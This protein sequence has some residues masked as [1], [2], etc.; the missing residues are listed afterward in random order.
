MEGQTDGHFYP[1]HLGIFYK[2]FDT[3]GKLKKSALQ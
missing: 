2:T 3:F 1:Q